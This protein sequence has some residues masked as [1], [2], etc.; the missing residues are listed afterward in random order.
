MDAFV[1]T[2]PYDEATGRLRELYDAD[3][4]KL[5][6]IP[7]YRKMISQ[8]PE[9]LEAWRQLESQVRSTMPARH[10]ELITEVAAACSRCTY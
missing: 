8:R 1:R 6:Y 4:A 9:V 10:Y 5:G 3:L 2:V 7:N